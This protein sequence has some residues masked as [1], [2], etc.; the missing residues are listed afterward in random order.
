MLLKTNRFNLLLHKPSEVSECSIRLTQLVAIIKNGVISVLLQYRNMDGYRPNSQQWQ[1]SGFGKV[2]FTPSDKM[3]IALEYSLL[4]NKIQM[5]GGLSDS[6]FNANPK[7]SIRSRNW[8]KSPWNIVNNSI[9]LTPNENTTISLKTTY[10]FS[11]RSLVW[12][13][14]DGGPSVLD[15]IDPAT[16]QFVPREVESED[17]HSIATEARISTNYNVGQ[18]S[19]YISSRYKAFVCKV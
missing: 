7:A 1:L 4:R 18:K 19:I 14:E 9:I 12:R 16:N 13:N 10:L 2:K 15:T 11:N 17:M 3:N 8:L 6:L 5:P